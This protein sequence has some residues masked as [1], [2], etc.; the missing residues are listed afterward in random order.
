MCGVGFYHLTSISVFIFHPFTNFFQITHHILYVWFCNFKSYN[1]AHHGKVVLCITSFSQKLINYNNVYCYNYE[2]WWFV[3][4]KTLNLLRNSFFI[5]IYIYNWN[6]SITFFDIYFFSA[7]TVT[8][9]ASL[10]LPI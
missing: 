2:L 5:Y 3:V 10:N 6:K 9:T 7:T 4:S 1:D 8:N